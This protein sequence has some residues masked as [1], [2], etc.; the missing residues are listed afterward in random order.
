[1]KTFEII[2]VTAWTEKKLFEKVTTTCADKTREGF[3]VISVSFTHYS[4]AYITIAR[5]GGHSFTSQI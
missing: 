4:Y 3:E 2:K 1:M 5:Q